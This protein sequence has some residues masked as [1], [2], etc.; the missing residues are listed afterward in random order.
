MDTER[1][2][3]SHRIALGIIIVILVAL[4]IVAIGAH[5]I[6]YRSAPS[7]ARASWAARLH[8]HQPLTVNDVGSIQ[9]WMTFDYINHIFSLPPQYIQSSLSITDTRY[10]RMTLAQYAGDIGA[11]QTTVL[12][13]VEQV[14]QVYLSEK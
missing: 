1:N 10:P 4:F 6:E 7:G 11:S 2:K 9:T 13:H 8:M 5:Y 14:V 3:T 12:A